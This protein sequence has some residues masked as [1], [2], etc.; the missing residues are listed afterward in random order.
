MPVRPP[1]HPHP[2]TLGVPRTY[3][4]HPLNEPRKMGT[5]TEEFDIALEIQD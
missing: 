2:D 1:L 5:D 4:N 3:K